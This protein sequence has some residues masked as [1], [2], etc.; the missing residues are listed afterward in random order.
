MALETCDPLARCLEYPSEHTPSA[1]R[2]AAERLAGDHPALA[3]S[4][5]ELA[6]WLETT[7]SGEARERYTG[8]F[9]LNPVC[10]LNVGYHLFGDTYA[11]GELLA[12][13]AGELRRAGLASDDLPDF[14]P[15]LLRLLPRLDDAEDRGLLAALLLR[16]ALER[17][18]REL[19]D[20]TSPWGAL[21]GALP[22]WL[23]EAFPG[24][25]ATSLDAASCA[26]SFP[27][28]APACSATCGRAGEDTAHA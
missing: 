22:A 16:P 13:L 26:P 14:L 18:V 9:D 19:S 23:G 7:P 1:A 2:A 5:W 27:G 20:S 8:L 24:D 4:L 15:T 11:R 10:T 17:M 21:L 25:H 12:G 28:V 3:R 6:V